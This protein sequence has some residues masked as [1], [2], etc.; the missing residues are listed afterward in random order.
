MERSPWSS[1]VVVVV[2]SDPQPIG[3]LTGTPITP[4]NASYTALIATL[5][6]LLAIA[7]A[8]GGVAAGGRL[9]TFGNDIGPESFGAVMTRGEE[10]EGN[11][12]GW[13][14]HT[15]IAVE[16]SKPSSE[17]KRRGHQAP[18]T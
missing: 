6:I 4:L 9:W 15:Q 3:S 5:V 13:L 16:S 7:S 18:H 8:I 1:T 14:I 11:A 12:V 10:G 17:V 2:M